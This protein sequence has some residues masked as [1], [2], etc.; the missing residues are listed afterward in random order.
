M[1][2]S[3]PGKEELPQSPQ[4]VPP[5]QGSPNQ[6]SW[7]LGSPQTPRLVLTCWPDA[8]RPCLPEGP[9]HHLC[10]LGPPSPLPCRAARTFSRDKACHCASLE[11]VSAVGG[12]G[13]L[14]VPGP[15]SPAR[16]ASWEPVPLQLRPR[17]SQQLPQVLWLATSPR[18][19]RTLDAEP[20][21]REPCLFYFTYIFQHGAA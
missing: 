6:V 20:S 10:T 19:A 16:P 2:A 21:Q 11:P 14:S 5:S 8:H 12:Q 7:T 17:E 1:E 9:L 13:V 15:V 4:P 3:T 18:L